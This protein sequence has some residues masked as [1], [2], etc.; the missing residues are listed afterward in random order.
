MPPLS[1]KMLD[2]NAEKAKNPKPPKGPVMFPSE[3]EIN[4]N[5]DNA[6]NIEEFLD[7]EKKN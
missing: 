7:K 2:R 1:Q 5:I 6:I 4:P 3:N